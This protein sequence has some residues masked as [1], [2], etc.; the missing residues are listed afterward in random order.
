MVV[1]VVG[2][3]VFIGIFVVALAWGL[4][5]RSFW[6]GV[7]FFAIV[8]AEGWYF[9]DTLIDIYETWK[10]GNNWL[11]GGRGEM[12]VHDV[13]KQLPPEYVI[14]ND[15]HPLK[16]GSEAPERW[17]VDHIVIG[18]SGVFVVE[19]K[20]YSRQF[21]RSGSKDV[22]TK[23]NVKQVDRNA[24]E[25]KD[26]IRKWSAGDL[27]SLFVV[28]VLVY[29]QDGARVESLRENNVRVLPLRLLAGE[30]ERHTENAI[31][32]DKAY[33]LARVLYS[34]MSVSERSPFE[35]DLIEYGR[36]A[37]GIT[38]ASNAPPNR[39][40][41]EAPSTPD[42]APVCPRCGATLVVKKA[43]RG[44]NAG[45]SFWACPGYPN[46]RHAEPILA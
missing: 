39:S 37:R 45:G 20:N 43:K 25:L 7:I 11:K 36:L 29:A 14:F 42:T 1:S 4:G 19:T 35:E 2:G 5:G 17:N 26:R 3:T 13:L 40:D 8:A 46:C 6:V 16:K 32:M 10:E 9:R 30:I 24:R 38:N 33:R 31:T 21:V 15:F 34:H 22:F 44:A 12:L 41:S 18:P 28:P 23:K 27:D